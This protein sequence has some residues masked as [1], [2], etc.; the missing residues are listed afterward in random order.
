MKQKPA[1][2]TS[3]PIK[4]PGTSRTRYSTVLPILLINALLAIS[5]CNQSL[6]TVI[7][8]SG[9]WTGSVTNFMDV[10]DGTAQIT[11]FFD[12]E[13]ELLNGN[14]TTNF[15]TEYNF[16]GSIVRGEIFFIWRNVE[17][18]VDFRFS[19][20]FSGRSIAGTWRMGDLS[21]FETLRNGQW[22]VTRLN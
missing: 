7:D 16:S 15:G 6:D 17:E 22:T 11:I 4:K 10:G 19:G 2:I 14:L 20:I 5:A 12:Q 8:V 18:G 21:T 1:M 3:G 13:E 9:F